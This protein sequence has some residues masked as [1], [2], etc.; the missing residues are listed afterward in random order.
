M[1][2]DWTDIAVI[3]A[4]ILTAL[5]VWVTIRVTGGMF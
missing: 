4:V 5:V 1:K 3:V 2:T